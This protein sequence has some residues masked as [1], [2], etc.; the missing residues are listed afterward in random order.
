MKTFCSVLPNNDL[1]RT[2]RGAALLALLSAAA[3]LVAEEG[4]S[5]RAIGAVRPF[6][7]VPAGETGFTK[8]KS[9]GFFLGIGEFDSRSQ[10]P[11]LTYAVDDAVALAHLFASELELLP[12]RNVRLALSGEPKS[13]RAKA[14]L[15]TLKDAGAKLVPP[16]KTEILF[17]IQDVSDAANE[18]EGLVVVSLASHG[19]EER[20]EAFVMP[21]D[22]NRRLIRDTG[23][24]QEAIR[25]TLD[26]SKAGKK[27]MIV[28]ACR[29]TPGG[30]TR[31]AGKMSDAL[32]KALQATEGF[33]VM[34][35]CKVGQLSW[36]DPELEQGVF[37][38]F[39]LE[40]FRGKAPA[41]PQ[42]GLI[43]LG[44]VSEYASKMTRDY[45]RRFK[46]ED[47]IPWFEGEQA[48]NIP[49]A[50][51]PGLRDELAGLKKRKD[52][53]PELLF[54]AR[55]EHSGV[56]TYQV[57]DEV[58]RAVA[59]TYGEDLKT[60]LAHVEN[61]QDASRVDVEGFVAWW[62]VSKNRYL[63]AAAPEPEFAQN[64]E[65]RAPA[66]LEERVEE[67]KTWQ[68]PEPKQ[69]GPRIVQQPE[70]LTATE[71]DYVQLS[72][73]V[74][75]KGDYTYLW[76]WYDDEAREW[77]YYESARD[78]VWNEIWDGAD[79]RYRCKVVGEGATLIS[80][81]ATVTVNP[82]SSD[83]GIYDSY[84]D[85]SKQE[86]TTSNSGYGD[87]YDSNYGQQPTYQQPQQPTVQIAFYAFPGV[88]CTLGPDGVFYANGNGMTNM[89]IGTFQVS[90]DPNYAWGL[91]LYP[92]WRMPNDQGY[93]MVRH[94]GTIVYIYFSGQWEAVGY[95]L[96]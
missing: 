29:E 31:G 28:D 24:S 34:A 39:L 22:G 26:N 82:R 73:T 44:S 76:E 77:T 79:G 93:R 9:Y 74:Q 50:V 87:G 23:V 18:R 60:L 15:K 14:K 75:P 11:E 71:G 92:Q 80:E 58:E 48:R 83:E 68:K 85:G 78:L 21:R 49:V 67:T 53:V 57:L 36:E 70:S 12:P 52:K 63:E 62:S 30:Q 37:T 20:G 46:N 6:E 90:P 16:T 89:P 69:T 61:L 55:R 13:D 5:T 32:L 45:V 4:A 7:P 42:D 1:R 38:H 64:E 88:I 19:F 94:D 86:T 33:A 40:G 41:S 27:L 47:Q 91:L 3:P 35:S 2:L 72:V 54:A 25:M 43:R 81:E 56:M 95:V 65:R 17:A 59:N 96:Q 84:G 66:R 8:E 10:L 51:S